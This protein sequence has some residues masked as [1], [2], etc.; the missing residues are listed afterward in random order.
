MRWLVV[1]CI[2]RHIRR[3]HWYDSGERRR[4]QIS[5]RDTAIGMSLTKET[6]FTEV[7]VDIASCRPCGQSRGFPFTNPGDLVITGG[8][9]LLCGIGEDPSPER[10]RRDIFNE[11]VGAGEEDEVIKTS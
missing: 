11:F 4:L 2:S 10:I 7:M 3:R 5:I 6:V 9:M 8:D 1:M